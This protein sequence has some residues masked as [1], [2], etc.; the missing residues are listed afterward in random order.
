MLTSDPGPDNYAGSDSGD[1]LSFNDHPRLGHGQAPPQQSDG[2]ADADGDKLINHNMN[3]GRGQLWW[4]P[5]L[6]HK[7]GEEEY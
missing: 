7:Q 2:D 5:C 6:H 4:F 1:W 3:E